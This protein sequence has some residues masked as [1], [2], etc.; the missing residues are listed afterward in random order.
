MRE[1]WEA[2]KRSLGRALD[3]PLGCHHRHRYPVLCDF[4]EARMGGA[5]AYEEI[6]PEVYKAP[7]IIMQTDWSHSVDI[8]NVACLVSSSTPPSLCHQ[9][10]H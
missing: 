3:K 5:Y 4:G 10:A 1:A 6:Q 2:P 9:Q 8:W 7:E